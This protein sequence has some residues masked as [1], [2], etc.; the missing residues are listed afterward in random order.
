VRFLYITNRG[1]RKL[2]FQNLAF[3]HPPQV[4]AGSGAPTVSSPPPIPVA[5]P[6][7]IM[8]WRMDF[9][10][11]VWI[12]ADPTNEHAFLLISLPHGQANTPTG[13]GSA[14]GLPPLAPAPPSCLASQPAPAT[15]P[16]PPASLPPCSS[17]P[18]AAKKDDKDQR[19][20]GVGGGA[21]PAAG[22]RPSTP[23]LPPSDGA[24]VTDAKAND[25]GDERG[26]GKGELEERRK[27]LTPEPSPPPQQHQQEHIHDQPLE[28]A[29]EAAEGAGIDY[30]MLEAMKRD[31]ERELQ[32]RIPQ[33]ARVRRFFVEVARKWGG[34]EGKG[35]AS[36]TIRSCVHSVHKY[37]VGTSDWGMENSARECVGHP[38]CTGLVFF[39]IQKFTANAALSGLGA[40]LLMASCARAACWLCWCAAPRRPRDRCDCADAAVAGGLAGGIRMSVVGRDDGWRERRDWFDKTQPPRYTLP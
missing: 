8:H 7:D 16:T 11:F 27:A 25:A 23:S 22:S 3:A 32:R 30:A 1:I 36:R 6:Q 33:D 40:R 39:T 37:A 38:H 35:W 2:V 5:R 12:G 13:T 18:A 24:K 21:V 9:R 28:D 34:R 14:P 15:P 20:S 29:R 10:E 17:L 4:Q 31:A 26:K 19:S